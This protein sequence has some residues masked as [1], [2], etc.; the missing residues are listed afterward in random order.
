MAWGLRHILPFL[1]LLF[2]CPTN[3]GALCYL[4][5]RYLSTYIL[6][7]RPSAHSYLYAYTLRVYASFSDITS[8]HPHQDKNKRWFLDGGDGNSTQL[9]HNLLPIT[10]TYTHAHTQP[11]TSAVLPPDNTAAI[12]ST[13]RAMF[14]PAYV[15][16]CD[17]THVH[18]L[19]WR[20]RIPFA[21]PNV[22]CDPSS[23][24]RCVY[25]YLY[26]CS[27]WDL[28]LSCVLPND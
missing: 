4:H 26:I 7:M 19:E 17:A 24:L 5:L 15:Y 13:I 14:A 25:V 27:G 1:S 9:E 11:L 23:A 8:T 2:Q 21:P 16:T 6:C 10:E 20:C 28:C 18:T 12:S 3:D 22:L